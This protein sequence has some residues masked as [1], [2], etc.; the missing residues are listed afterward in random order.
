MQ[1]YAASAGSGVE[2]RQVWGQ[3]LLPRACLV[4]H[5][6]G[7][8]NRTNIGVRTFSQLDTDSQW[9]G[10][11]SP[12]RKPGLLRAIMAGVEYSD[13]N[14]M[15]KDVRGGSPKKDAQGTDLARSAQ[16]QKA[17]APPL[18]HI[19]P[20]SLP[21][22]LWQAACRC[23][24]LGRHGILAVV[25]G[26][27]QGWGGPRTFCGPASPI[28]VGVAGGWGQRIWCGSAGPC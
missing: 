7:L 19:A 2:R 18:A 23:R 4:G 15:T 28:L 1:I 6:R 14:A 5:F 16:P 26:R 3:L 24:A 11:I 12:F 9:S 27:L 21:G 10:A 22:R 17:S 20:G 25:G 8:A 13:E